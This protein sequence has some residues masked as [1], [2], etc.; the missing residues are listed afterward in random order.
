MRKR[1][2]HVHCAAYHFRMINDVQ[3]MQS[4]IKHTATEHSIQSHLDSAK[5]QLF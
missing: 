5:S 1:R 2:V 3:I 4:N